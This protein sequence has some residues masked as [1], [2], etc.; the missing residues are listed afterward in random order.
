MMSPL[1]IALPALLLSSRNWVH[2]SHLPQTHSRA[3]LAGVPRLDIPEYGWTEE[4]NTGAD[5][6]CIGPDRCPTT[7]PSAANLAASFNRTLWRHKGAV[8]SEEI[9]ALNNVHGHRGCGPPAFIGVNEWG[10]NINLI[11]GQV[12]HCS[13]EGPV[14]CFCAECCVQCAECF[15]SVRSAVSVQR[16]VICAECCV[17]VA[18]AF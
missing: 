2:Q 8:V 3:R 5:S 1:A 11:R 4:A 17:V 6:S 15:A 10:P 12:S 13:A 7:F 18:R 9:R 14:L 16:C